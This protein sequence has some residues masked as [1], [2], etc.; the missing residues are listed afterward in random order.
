MIPCSDHRGEKWWFCNTSGSNR[1]K[2]ILPE[3]V[4]KEFLCKE[5]VSFEYADL[6][7]EQEEDLFAR[8]QMGV[9]LSLAEK[10]RAST[11]PW[12]ELA[13][14]YVDD[15]PVIYSLLK[16]RARAKDFQITLSCFSQIIEVQ[17]PTAANGIPILKTNYTSLPKLLQNK[18]AVDDGIKSHLASVWNIFQDLLN[19]DPNTFTNADRRL[20]GV[21][22]FAPVE[23][24]ATTVLISVHSETR[25]NRLLIGDIQALR[26]A[27]REN[28]VDLRMATPVWRFI[29]KFIDDL[30]QIRGAVDGTTVD[31]SVEHISTLPRQVSAQ[32]TASAVGPNA[33]KKRGRPTAKTKS[34]IVI[35]GEIGSSNP[36]LI[37][38]E[39]GTAATSQNP[40]TTKRPRLDHVPGSTSSYPSSSTTPSPHLKES[41]TQGDATLTGASRA[42]PH[43]LHTTH[44]PVSLPSSRQ[45]ALASGSPSHAAH[46]RLS[47]STPTAVSKATIRSNQETPT[48]KTR[49]LFIPSPVTP[50][51]PLLARTPLITPPEARQNRISELNSY[52]P[53]ADA[54]RT[55]AAASIQTSHVPSTFKSQHLPASPPKSPTTSSLLQGVTWSIPSHTKPPSQY[56]TGSTPSRTTPQTPASTQSVTAL[57]QAATSGPLR[58]PFQPRDTLQRVSPV[59]PRSLPAP[60]HHK[61]KPTRPIPQYD[62]A[63]D[64]IDLTSDTEEEREFLL[65]SFKNATAAVPS[66]RDHFGSET[67]NI[68]T[69]RLNGSLTIDDTLE[70]Q[71]ATPRLPPRPLQ[72]RHL[73][74]VEDLTMDQGPVE[75]SNP[76]AHLKRKRQV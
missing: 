53:T 18:G 21:Q 9:Q 69:H 8:V 65:S 1:R 71:R 59:E 36:A 16:D 49:N 47:Q 5:L 70:S 72:Q 23:M 25:N 27:L 34:T 74:V 29:W 19:L 24:I 60:K 58:Q 32:S 44:Q 54:M 63:I 17:H 57:T 6:A 41:S 39:P 14:C 62:G 11:G 46:K 33:V 12:Q 3:H 61:K 45:N 73:M 40:H 13:R 67:A 20:K 48:Q 56:Q 26:D 35:P 2:H 43:A 22:T 42:H 52:L 64:T 30:E 4:K 50:S 55:K 38:A 7:P 15:F 76:Y 66:S 51:A 68:P 75:Y 10:M 28:F 37:K 31:R